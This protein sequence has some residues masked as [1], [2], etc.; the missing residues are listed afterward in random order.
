MVEIKCQGSTAAGS[1]SPAHNGEVAGDRAGADSRA[2]EVAGDGL[3]WRGGPRELTGGTPAARTGSEARERWRGCSR[4][5]EGTFVRNPG[6]GE[7][8]RA[9]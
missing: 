8:N 2:F 6:C 7:G 5:V 9:C 3:D 4:R 1:A